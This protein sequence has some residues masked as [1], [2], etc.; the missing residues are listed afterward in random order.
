MQDY[1]DD[2]W[3]EEREIEKMRKRIAV[4][5]YITRLVHQVFDTDNLDDFGVVFDRFT[6]LVV[7]ECLALID[8]ATDTE[9]AKFLIRDK[10]NEIG[11]R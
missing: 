5:G 4:R 1:D 7:S 2:D 10:F 3:D 6:R 8:T 11:K 9:H